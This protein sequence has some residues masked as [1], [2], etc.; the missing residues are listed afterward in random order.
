MSNNLLKVIVNADD[1]G[2]SPGVS[3][4]ILYAHR[5]GI[6]TSTTAMVNTSFARQSVEM[7]RAYSELGIG[8]HFVLDKGQPVSSSVRSLTD[9][10][11]SFLKGE[12]LIKSA[13]KD[14]I[15]EELETQ[16]NILLDWGVDVTHIDSHHHM[17]IHIPAAQEAITEI[18]R[19]YKLPIRSLQQNGFGKDILT[20]DYFIKDFYG[21]ENV[22]PD[23]LIHILSNL[24]S[25]VTEI[26]SHPAFIDPWLQNGSSYNIPRMKE[27]ET[28]VDDKVQTWVNGHNIQLINYGHIK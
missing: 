10:T 16:L 4:G 19:E 18:A 9:T 21:Q 1:F 26:M 17:H 22:L 15:K 8:L 6:L 20:N 5:F 28:L 3:T 7:A 2:Y 14:D 27:L 13:K 11:G 23:S 24:K 25:G 12:E